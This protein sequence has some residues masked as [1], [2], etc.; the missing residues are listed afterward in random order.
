M[1]KILSYIKDTHQNDFFSYKIS[2]VSRSIKRRMKSC[3][4]HSTDE[5]LELL[6]LKPEESE[7]LISEITIEYS[8]FFRDTAAFEELK[9]DVLGPLLEN[10]DENKNGLR[11]WSAGCAGGEEAYSISM[12]LFEI[13]KGQ[14]E[15]YA[16]TIFATDIDERSLEKARTGE[17]QKESISDVG[18]LMLKRY[19]KR[20][21][22][23]FCVKEFIKEPVCVGKHNF[24]EDPPIS[25][26]DLVCCRNVLIYFQ[27]EAQD[28]ALKALYYAINPGGF[29]FLGQAESVPAVTAMGFEIVSR[30]NR[31]FRKKSD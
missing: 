27:K 23:L 24:L 19:F 21:G 10:W 28:K 5:Y 11:I 22:D 7:R 2:S 13:T 6:Q 17:Y 14:F 20:R 31:I 4:C 18:P 29:L 1:E 9:R 30:E 25:K 15:K 16:P 12:L 26:L 3:K 8:Y